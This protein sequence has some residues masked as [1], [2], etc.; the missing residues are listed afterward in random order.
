M[1]EI[2][3]N[4]FSQGR[5][6]FVQ[7]ENKIWLRELFGLTCGW[8]GSDEGFTFSRGMFLLDTSAGR[9]E[10]DDLVLIEQQFRKK[11]V[12]LVWVTADKKMQVE[13]DWTLCDQTGIWSRKDKVKN[14]SGQT[15]TV[16][17]CL[18]RF[19][20]SP[21]TYE[22]YS[23]S[24][25]WC[26]ENQGYWQDLDHG[27]IV[28][29]CEQAR[30]CQSG[31]PYLY[32]RD[33]EQNRGVAFYILPKGNWTIR[34]NAQPFWNN[35]IP[36]TVIEL[37]QGIEN[38]KWQLNA[39]ETVELPQILIQGGPE[40]RPHLAA[41]R[42]Q[43]YLL[44]YYFIAAKKSAP[45]IYNTWF[46]EFDHL[47]VERMRKQLAAAKTIGC[48]VFVIDAGWYGQSAGDWAAQTGDWREKLDGAFQGKMKDF[49][50]EVR[51]AGLGF[52][53]WMEPERLCNG[54][55]A[56][57]EHPDWFIKSPQGFYPDLQNKKAYAYIFGE[58]SR[59]VE[60]YQLV[61]MKIDF[62]HNFGVDAS[63]TEFFSYYEPWYRMLDELRAKFPKMFF[64]ACASG[65]MRSD[66]H[67]LAHFDG[68]FLSDT[69]N[70]ID[71]L[72]IYQGAL[73]R[74]PAGRMTK[75]I[76]LR[77]AGK[78]VPEYGNLKEMY[79][80]SYVTPSSAVWESP[81]I[82]DLDFIVRAA[83]TGMP[84][85]SGDL[86]GLPNEGLD[87]LKE[88]V[89]WY[90]KWRELIVGSISHLLTPPGRKED[91]TGWIGLQLQHPLK[92]TS[93]VFVYRLDDQTGS[94]RFNLR[95][96]E[97][98]AKYAVRNTDQKEI[99]KLTGAELMD[100][101]LVVDLPI[102]HRAAVIE[103]IKENE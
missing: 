60:Q 10:A 5:T 69:V 78:S 76:C 103:V 88:H 20:F 17:K 83:L 39:K 57:K 35:S 77:S 96:L 61:W 41:P 87:R 89:A 22:I 32:L 97:P 85:F 66:A 72:R 8:C 9:Y 31:T 12:R 7:K 14:L 98:N 37:G 15:V 49:A 79:P 16:F 2:L 91:R 25:R 30:T 43:R 75:W 80:P 74:L 56:V 44:K 46:D 99:N 24:S 73:L 23:Q 55:P 81:V 64:E 50:N 67:T 38:L 53:I 36:F 6:A 45:V 28:L 11:S 70:P 95:D 94:K 90:K 33:K 52:G 54:V 62:N 82:T 21:G 13:S 42:L 101:G 59:L 58:I 34:V 102:I 26:C 40:G 68:H 3:Y 1:K 100:K 27:K 92:S 51:A 84:G 4:A 19:V 65:G 29:G 47:V 48:E 93:L 63:G 86:A 71:V 18:A